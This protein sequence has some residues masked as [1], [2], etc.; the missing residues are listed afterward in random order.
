VPA[1]LLTLGTPEEVETYCKKLID[2]VGRGGGF[3]LSSG[4]TVPYNAKFENIK[5]MIN[6]G[7]TYQLSK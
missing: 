4:C 7:K 3:I 5:A 6:T 2:E 1:S